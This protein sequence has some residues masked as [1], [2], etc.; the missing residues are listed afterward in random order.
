MTGRARVGER[1]ALIT[2]KKNYTHFDWNNL[3]QLQTYD[4]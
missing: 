4:I 1:P 2:D 3:V